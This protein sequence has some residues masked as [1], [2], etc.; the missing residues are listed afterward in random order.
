MN[1]RRMLA[2]VLEAITDQV[3]EELDKMRLV[4]ENG[5]ERVAGDDSRGLLNGGLAVTMYS[6]KGFVVIGVSMD[7]DGWKVLRPFLDGAQGTL[8]DATWGQPHRKAIRN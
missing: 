5:R 1:Q 2:A 6:E 3:L 7:Q 8:P 4:A